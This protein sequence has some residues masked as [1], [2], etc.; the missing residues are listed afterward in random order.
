MNC[1]AMLHMG[2]TVTAA[3]SGPQNNAYS[4][5]KR[6]AVFEKEVFKWR[7]GI[8]EPSVQIGAKFLRAGLGGQRSSALVHSVEGKGLT[9][10]AAAQEKMAAEHDDDRDG[11]GLP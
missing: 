11:K 8:A 2:P 1:V 5:D 10:N 3:Q 4:I 6:R 7:L 9:A